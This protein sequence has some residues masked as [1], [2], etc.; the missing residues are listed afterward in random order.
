MVRLKDISIFKLN[1]SILFQFQYGTIKR[2]SQ[3]A[4]DIAIAL[5]Q[6]QYG[7]IKSDLGGLTYK[8]VT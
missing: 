6:F 7:T 8:G 4:V 5:F 1:T 3:K 2:R